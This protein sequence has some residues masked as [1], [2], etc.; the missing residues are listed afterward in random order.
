[1]KKN[2]LL[3]IIFG[4]V[5]CASL[6]LVTFLVFATDTEQDILNM[7]M[8]P[9]FSDE[10]APET[11]VRQPKNIKILVSDSVDIGSVP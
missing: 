3:G 2:I 5:I 7:I 8:M 4:G 9:E 1:M 6:I 10:S 11:T